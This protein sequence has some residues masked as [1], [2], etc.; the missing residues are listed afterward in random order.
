MDHAVRVAREERY[1]IRIAWDQGC[2]LG[3]WIAERAA[4]ARVAIFADPN[5]W[6]CH[7]EEVRAALRGAGV[8]PLVLPFAGGELGKDWSAARRAMDLLVSAGVQRRDLLVLF[9]GG[10][11]CDAG[12]FVAAVFMRG[13]PYVN[14]PTTL[15][16]QVDAAIGGKVAVNH[17]RAKNLIGAFHH[18]RGV[19]VNPRFLCSLPPEELRN[20]FAEMVKVALVDRPG[21]FE[22]ME[23]D[24]ESLLGARGVQPEA[25][26][27]IRAAVRAKLDLL[28]PDPFEAELRRPLNLGHALAHALETAESYRGLRHGFAVAVGVA[29]AVRIACARG[30]L[31]RELAG[32]V[33]S[34]LVRAGLPTA[35]SRVPAEAV[36]EHMALIRR[37]RGGA[38]HEV[39]PMGG[40]RCA[41]VDDLTLEE[42]CCAYAARDRDLLVQEAA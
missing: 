14:V 7:G 15:M 40:G 31:D 32:R 37:I 42:F 11:V 33:H 26:Q 21:S 8:E 18:P 38:L 4:G 23:S 22:L 39:L 35:A 24:M 29:V 1:S 20:G 17:P 28:A 5:P 13:V 12:G 16:A 10:V 19:Y 41:I 3:Q 34:L 6:R 36:W 25:I 9:G 2:G 30:L 27:P